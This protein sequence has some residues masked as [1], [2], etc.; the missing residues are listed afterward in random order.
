[1]GVESSQLPELLLFFLAT[2]SMDKSALSISQV[3]STSRVLGILVHKSVFSYEKV[4]N[5][6]EGFSKS[7]KMEQGGFGVVYYVELRGEVSS[8]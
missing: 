4:F 7:N 6:T 5:G 3:D 1:M 8:I 2:T